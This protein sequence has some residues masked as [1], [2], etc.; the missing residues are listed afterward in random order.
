MVVFHAIITNV[1]AK[2]FFAAKANAI[3]LSLHYVA[4]SDTTNLKY[5]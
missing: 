5:F 1:P 2:V 3:L 4:L